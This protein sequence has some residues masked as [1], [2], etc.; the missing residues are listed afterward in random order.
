[1]KL[2]KLLIPHPVSVVRGLL[3]TAITFIG[4]LLFGSWSLVAVILLFSLGHLMIGAYLKIYD[5]VRFQQINYPY[6]KKDHWR[7]GFVAG[8]VCLLAALIVGIGFLLYLFLVPGIREQ[9]FSSPDPQAVVDS[10]MWVINIGFAIA[11]IFI[12]H[13]GRLKF[14]QEPSRIKLKN[15]NIRTK[16]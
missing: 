5:P 2:T 3:N 4:Q 13:F 7:E 11:A 9:V 10:W 12:Y 8:G 1:M 14:Y 6:T 16:T 15:K